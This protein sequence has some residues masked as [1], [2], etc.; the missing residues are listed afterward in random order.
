MKIYETDSYV[1]EFEATVV[2][3]SGNK[4]FLD[5]TAFY[6][7]G[8]G[9]PCDTGFIFR[10]KEKF[11]VVSVNKTPEGSISHEVSSEG[12]KEGDSVFCRIDWARRYLFMRYHTACHLLSGVINKETGAQI[13]GNQI[14]EDKTRIDFSLENFNKAEIK[15]Y[16]DK[17]NSLIEQN[18]PVNVK[19]LPREEAFKIPSIVKLRMNLPE[20]IKEVRVIEIEGFDMQA[21]GGTHVRNTSEVGKIEITKIENKGKANRRIQFKLK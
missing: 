19:F 18:L 11:P 15:K 14:S 1:R 5:K 2:G 9:Q 8:G 17:V 21:C 4:V 6:P 7:E 20:E 10:D 16:E 13:T 12:L 3:V